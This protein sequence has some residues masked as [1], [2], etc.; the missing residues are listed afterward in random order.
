MSACVSVYVC[1]SVPV[2]VCVQVEK[3]EWAVRKKRG[4]RMLK[5]FIPISVVR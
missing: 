4:R 3:E 2:C 5:I 1:V